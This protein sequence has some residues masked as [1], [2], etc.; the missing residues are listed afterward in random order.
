MKKITKGTILKQAITPIGETK[1]WKLYEAIE[2]DG[3]I[4]WVDKDAEM[5][6]GDYWYNDSIGTCWKVTH[7]NIPLYYQPSD[8]NRTGMDKIVASTYPLDG[9][10]MIELED[11]TEK[12][13]TQKALDRYG[14]IKEVDI[15]VTKRKMF[16]RLEYYEGLMDGYKANPAKYTEEDVM[17]AYDAGIIGGCNPYYSETE[18]EEYIQQLNTLHTIEVDENFKII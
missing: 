12:L 3:G 16:G 4:V 15:N 9:I 18:R 14:T 11:N 8:M 13:F 1:V 2:V 7:S 10:P 6:A 5:V 17:N